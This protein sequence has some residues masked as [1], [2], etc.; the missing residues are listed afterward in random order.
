M[1]EI[2][3]KGWYAIKLKQRKHNQAN[4]VPNHFEHYLKQ[5]YLN[6]RLDANRYFYSGPEC[7]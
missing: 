3:Y 7:T 6:Q 1:H 4:T 5:N 2:T